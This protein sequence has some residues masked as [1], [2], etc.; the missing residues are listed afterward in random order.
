MGHGAARRAMAKHANTR[1]PP[2]V[3]R[4]GSLAVAAVPED[5]RADAT[6]GDLAQTDASTS[7]RQ[8]RD[9][10]T[11]LRYIVELLNHHQNQ[12]KSAS[13]TS[14][15]SWTRWW[16][17]TNARTHGSQQHRRH[18]SSISRHTCRPWR[19]GSPRSS[20]RGDPAVPRR[21]LRLSCPT[22]RRLPAQPLQ[23]LSSPSRQSAA[24][25]SMPARE[26]SST[27]SE[28]LPEPR[29]RHHPRSPGQALLK[30]QHM[31]R[32]SCPT[33]RNRRFEV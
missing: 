26:R 7:W 19:S 8:P 12:H 10:R 25:S 1:T 22:A 4:K 15:G 33:A 28:H 27:T 23:P 3:R 21:H 30:H 17:S 5:P 32:F 2:A 18:S 13:T 20:R 31:A 9:D 14:G 6:R 24:E 29:R 16:T 11:A